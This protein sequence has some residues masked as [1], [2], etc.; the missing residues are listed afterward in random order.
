MFDT[1]IGG[2]SEVFETDFGFHFV[3]VTDKRGEQYSACHV[4]MKPK[5]DPSELDRCGLRIDSLHTDLV[6][7]VRN[8]DSAV[9][10]YSTNE[11]SS[12]QKG[13][14]VNARDG[15]I[16][17][18]VDELD[19]TIYFILD[20]LTEGGFSSPVRLVDADG[21]GYWAIL[22]LDARHP[23]HRANPNDDFALFQSQVESELRFKDLEKWVK[24]HVGI[25]Y[26][27]LDPAYDSCN[28]NMDW[29]DYIWSSQK[30]K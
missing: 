17:F 6:A 3:K 8:F 22:R 25:T 20:P 13:Q 7:G 30:E 15:G 14:V 21:N 4:L 10:E 26:I 27:R 18:G 9:L 11:T 19:P 16:K 24:K 2:Y 1:P 29:D 28:F 5:V 23:A 12:N